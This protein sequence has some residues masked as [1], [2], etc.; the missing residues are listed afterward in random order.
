[1]GYL[2]GSTYASR[3]AAVFFPLVVLVAAMGLA[4]LPSPGPR[5]LGGAAVVLLGLS[6]AVLIARADRTEAGDFAAAFRA[7]AG[8][9]DVVVFC[10]DQ[11]GPAVNRM[12]PAALRQVV[13]PTFAGPERVDWAGYAE[14]NRESDP[15][16][17]ADRLVGEVPAEAT[18]WVV[19]SGS[20][21]TLEGTCEAMLCA[22]AAAGRPVTVVV[23]ENG[24]RFFEHA[25]L[26]R[27]DPAR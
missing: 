23:P 7:D 1:M 12:L 8:A 17:F 6:G 18:L 9:G 11:L 4:R 21:R 10:P 19:T 24:S 2:T 13:Y 15:A 20:Y 16:A 14:R 26:F 27:A 3:Y 5:L 22:V 25:S